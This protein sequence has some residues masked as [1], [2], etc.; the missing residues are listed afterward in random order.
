MVEAGW[1]T[2]VSGPPSDVA[3]WAS[4]HRLDEAAPGL[5]AAGHVE[6][7]QP[8]GQRHLALGQVVL[9]VRGEARVAHPTRPSG[10]PRAA[11]PARMRASRT[12][13]A[14]RTGSVR[15]PR[16]PFSA[17]NGDAMAPW[18]TAKPQSHVEQLRARRRPRRG[19]RRC[20]RRCALVAECT[21]RSTPWSSGRWH[22]RRGE[23]R[24]D[25]R[26]RAGDGAELVEV[27]EVEA[28]GWPASRPTRAS[29]LPGPDGGGE[30]AGL[31]AVDERDV[32]AEAGA[33]G[34]QQQLGAGVELALGDDVVAGRAEAEDHAA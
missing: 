34:L 13:G 2:S 4:S 22:E 28:A 31:G 1:V 32:D 15:M 29:V 6:A 11:R 21:T 25:H 20:G 8:A 10:G 7:E 18:R 5:E 24:V 14:S 12:G 33:H 30:R 3:S 19:W 27:D 16:R 23:G 26:D 17:S 9:R